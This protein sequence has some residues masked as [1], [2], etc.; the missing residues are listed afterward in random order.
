M[1]EIGKLRLKEFALAALDFK[2]MVIENGEHLSEQHH[3]SFQV[4]AIH[5]D[6]IYED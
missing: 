6:V 3:V 4:F 1:P 2:L 5:Q